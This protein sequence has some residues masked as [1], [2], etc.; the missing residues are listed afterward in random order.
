METF[1]HQ[2]AARILD[3]NAGAT[4]DVL[5]VFNNHRSEKFLHR[6]F[7]RVATERDLPPFFLPETTVIDDLVGRLGGLRTVRNEFLLFELYTIHMAI[8]GDER[9]YQTFEDFISFGDLMLG[10]FSE[11]DQYMVDARALF[12]NLYDLKAIG[13]WDVSNPNLSDFQRRYL[14]FYRS[15]YDYYTQLRARLLARGEAY[16]GMA[17]RL[18]AE[19]IDTLVDKVPYRMVYFVG[20]NALSE[21]ERRIIRAFTDRGR[22]HLLTD[23]DAYYYDNPA[24]EAGY[25][26]RKHSAEFADLGHF[27]PSAFGMQKKNITIADCPENVLQ[28]K[29]A[30]QV[31]AEHPEWLAEAESTAVV[32]ADESLLIPML[33]ALPDP[34][35]NAN[36]YRVNVSMG[37]AFADTHVH[38][39]VLKVIALYKNH[40]SRGFY[41][42]DVVELLSDFYIGRLLRAPVLRHQAAR[43]IADGNH[44]RLDSG[45]IG[46][47]LDAVGVENRLP[48]YLFADGEPGVDATLAVLKSLG[49][50]LLAAG[51]VAD[52]KK[53]L[54]AL[55]GLAEILDF[56]QQLQAE[57]NHMQRLDTLEKIYTRLA[58]R[59]SLDFLGQPIE[60]LQI[61]GM[62]ETRNLDFRRVILLSAGEGILPAGRGNNTLIPYELKRHAGL[63]TYE[64]K[65]NI[66]AYHFYRLI[67][68]AEE[69]Y[70]LFSSEAETMGKGEESRFVRQVRSELREAF[71]DTVSVTDV[72]VNAEQTTALQPPE[73]QA[74]KSPAVV[75]TLLDLAGR[76]FSP[77]GLNAYVGCPMK[78]YYSYVLKIKDENELEDDIDASQLGTAI[79]QTLRDIYAPYLGRE[80]ELTGLEEGLAHLPELLQH[81]FDELFAH[82][83][84]DEGRN[85]F[86]VAVA[87]HQ[88]E[89]MLRKEIDLL[90]QGNRMEII[91]LE[92]RLEYQLF[93][94]PD[95]HPVR[96][97]GDA[98]RID[99]FNG[100]LRV[101]DYKT[102]AFSDEEIRYTGKKVKDKWLQ[103][104]C[105]ALMYAR[106]HPSPEPLQS[107]IYPL[108]YTQSGV[109]LAR[110]GESDLIT[111]DNLRQ[112]EEL[113]VGLVSD[114]LDPEQP[115][116]AS[117]GGC[118][119]C[120]AAALCPSARTFKPR[121]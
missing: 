51:V 11:V 117:P 101:I 30:G 50:D 75:Q 37:F 39:L 72:V 5:V 73:A 96:L 57:Y 33:G 7:A 87:R 107:G 69:V 47:M 99:R 56:L 118:A 62:L 35:G 80:V 15:L 112:F 88:A 3:E 67:Q 77:T 94:T 13:E 104:M 16:G 74:A 36:G 6:E 23:G 70:L 42:R 68:R 98:D 41:H 21:C 28:C 53:E 78:F 59:H 115:F 45:A 58:R 1:L 76:G 17:Y 119:F 54:Q 93:T 4:D 52:N 55:G 121:L 64:E 111:P 100:R 85:S 12:V 90:R 9:K 82:G 61:L 120:P 103:L 43:Y 29:Y 95:G 89:A 71:P 81:N 2:V 83:R 84:S 66:F 19:Q 10:D 32:L 8:A 105:Y 49:A 22:G 24:Q 91:G 108:R 110:Q 109:R 46:E 113:L 60:D 102:G 40:T 34:G 65:D 38:S 27:G 31:L 20:F 92:Q 18:V 116:V 114:L 26:L 86:M 79:H 48:D 14:D 44:V 25:F 106:S 97:Y 63:P